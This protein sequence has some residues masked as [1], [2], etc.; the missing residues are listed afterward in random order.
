MAKTHYMI[1]V[2]AANMGASCKGTYARVAV[3]EV[4]A[5]AEPEMISE[6]AKGVVRIVRTWEKRNVG[7]G[8]GKCAYSKALTE[9]R[10]FAKALKPKRPV[11]DLVI[12]GNKAG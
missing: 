3:L 9:A 12:W 5:G 11:I 4:E 10:A 2:A 7:N 6:R 1:K 8:S